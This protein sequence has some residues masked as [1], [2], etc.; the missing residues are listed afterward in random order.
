MGKYE[1]SI[2][3]ILFSYHE[4]LGTEISESIFNEKKKK[5][6]DKKLD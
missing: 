3:Q 6:R 4:C 1:M 2:F 5:K